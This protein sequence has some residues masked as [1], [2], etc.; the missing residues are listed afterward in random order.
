MAIT[1]TTTSTIL[2]TVS[3]FTLTVYSERQYLSGDTRH[4][5]KMG[6]KNAQCDDGK[7]D[8]GVDWLDDARN[9]TCYHP[10]KRLME[11]DTRSVMECENLPTDYYPQHF[12]MGTKLEYNDTVPHH[13][14]HRPIWPMFGEYQFVPPQ[15]WLHNI[16]HGAV[17]ML[18][19]PCTH[20]TLVD[21]L[22]SLVTSCI[23]KHIIT[24]YTNLSEEQPLALVS[25]GC[26]LLMSNVKEEE[27]VQFIRERGLKGPEG[28]YPKEGQYTHQLI[29]LAQPPPGS[30]MEDSV[31]CPN[32]V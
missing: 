18:Y 32:H 20:H 22:R 26:R 10:D 14:D 11:S 7:T 30:D 28:A 13:G 3:L 17:V 12:C 2:L 21:K 23:R 9:F 31:I 8:L 6:E 29:K 24:P 4:K 16:E 27:V 5:V 25:W 15:R 1:T 19:H